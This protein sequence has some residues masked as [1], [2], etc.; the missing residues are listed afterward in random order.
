LYV[1]DL[2]DASLYLMENVDTK[3]MAKLCLDY[4]VNKDVKIKDLKYV[5]KSIVG[6]YGEMVR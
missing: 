6:L 2:A 1:D 4:F 5:I 3:D